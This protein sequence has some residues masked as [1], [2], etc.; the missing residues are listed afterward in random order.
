MVT[1]FIHSLLLLL[2]G[3]NFINSKYL[4]LTISNSIKKKNAFNRKLLLL[5]A[6][7]SINGNYFY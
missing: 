2:A 6:S 5:M 7:N 3:N 4:S 1:I